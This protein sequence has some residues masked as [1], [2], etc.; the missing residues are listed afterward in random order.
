MKF[1]ARPGP[2]RPL[3]PVDPSY[4]SWKMKSLNFSARFIELATEING[5]M[6]STWRRRWATS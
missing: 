3:H 5:H 4:L 1:E 6:R 2:R